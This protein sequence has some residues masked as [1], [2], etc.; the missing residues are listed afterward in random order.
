[1]NLVLILVE[2]IVVFSTLIFVNKFLGKY[3]VISF[4]GVCTVLANIF[5]AKSM[6]L[7]GDI[8]T[9]CGTVL[10]ASTFLATDILTENYGKKFATKA[11][12]VG[13]LSNLL[14]IITSQLNLYYSP[15]VWSFE[16][17]DAEKVLFMMS[18]RVT[19]SSMIM[20]FISNMVDVYLYDKLKEKTGSKYMWLRNNVCTILCNGLE[21]FFFMYGAFLFVPGYSVTTIFTMALTTTIIEAVIGLMDTPFL[22]LSKVWKFKE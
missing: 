7:F 4:V 1:M 13:F 19:I 22:Y 6:M 16:V 12:Y 21:N 11:I 14:L 10:F 3:G 5:T 15:A 2:V 17:H 20:Y 8:S 18:L 9:T